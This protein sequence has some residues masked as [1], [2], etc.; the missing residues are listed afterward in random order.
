MT[1][2]ASTLRSNIYRLLD[3][4]VAT[5]KPLTV[6]RKGAKLTIL[7]PASG[8]KLARLTP[9]RCIKGDPEELVHIDWSGEWRHDLP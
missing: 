7:P 1:V 6:V 8:G 5:G 9:H 2:N 4:V 3:E